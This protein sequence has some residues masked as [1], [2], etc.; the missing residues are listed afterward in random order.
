VHEKQSK[1]LEKKVKIFP[2]RK[3]DIA[4]WFSGS[5][6]LVA[7]KEGIPLERLVIA[8]FDLHSRAIRADHDT[9]PEMTFQE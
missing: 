1:T 8:S 6:Y 3:P 4:F 5:R 2:K 7:V 9:E